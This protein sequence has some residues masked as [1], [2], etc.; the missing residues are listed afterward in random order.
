MSSTVLLPTETDISPSKVRVGGVC[1]IPSN[2]KGP[3]Q[4]RKNRPSGLGSSAMAFIRPAI[5]SGG[6]AAISSAAAA[7][8]MIS[9]PSTSWLP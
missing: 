9:A 2:S 5:A 7:E 8:A 6:S 4:R 1:R 3:K